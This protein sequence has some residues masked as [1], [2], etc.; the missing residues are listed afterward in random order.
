MLQRGEAVTL[1]I[2]SRAFAGPE[3]ADYVFTD[4]VLSSGSGSVLVPLN[5]AESGRP[6]LTGDEETGPFAL[7][8][9]GTR[10]TEDGYASRAFVTGSTGALINE[11]DLETDIWAGID[12]EEL[13]LRVTDTLFGGA[14]LDAGIVARA[15]VR[16]ALSVR[17][18]TA[19]TLAVFMLPALVLAAAVAVL[20][21]RRRK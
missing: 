20:G 14:S 4:T 18:H 13:I 5:R 8:L 2:N 21:I 15:A 10:I 6:A 7:A 16:P 11:P 9:Y 3:S 1:V 17:S 12:T 19:G